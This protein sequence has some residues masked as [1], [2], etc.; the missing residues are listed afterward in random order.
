MGRAEAT[1]AAGLAKAPDSHVE[2]QARTCLGVTDN[3]E[4]S[5]P[6][7]DDEHSSPNQ[8]PGESEDAEPGDGI[9]DRQQEPDPVTRTPL[10]RGPNNPAR[11][12]SE[13]SVQFFTG[14]NLGVLSGVPADPH[15]NL[16]DW[17]PKRTPRLFD[18][19]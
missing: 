10:R 8:M 7:K 18:E 5:P 12:G 16:V 1:L 15:P 11:T 3:V 9:G 19:P 13:S 17:Q 2:Y 6:E 14:R 4:S